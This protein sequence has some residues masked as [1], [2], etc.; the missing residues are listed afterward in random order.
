[1]ALMQHAPRGKPGVKHTGVAA[2]DIRGGVVHLAWLAGSGAKPTQAIFRQETIDSRLHPGD[3]IA[4][5]AAAIV[6]A[7]RGIDLAK[8]P[9]SIVLPNTSEGLRVKRFPQMR[10]NALASAIEL[11]HS[12]GAVLEGAAKRSRHFIQ[13]SGTGDDGKRF[14]EAVLVEVTE[15]AVDEAERASRSAGVR[16]ARVA[17]PALALGRVLSAMGAAKG[18]VLVIDLM[19]PQTVLNTYTDGKFLLSR[20]AD[21]AADLLSDE[22]ES[23]DDLIPPGGEIDSGAAP[24]LDAMG[25]AGAAAATTATVPGVATAIAPGDDGGAVLGALGD[26][27]PQKLRIEIVRSNR[28]LMSHYRRPI[29]RVYFAG[30]AR[31]AHALAS[32]LAPALGVPVALIDPRAVVRADAIDGQPT[33]ASARCLGAAL[34][35]LAPARARGYQL[36][37]PKKSLW[38]ELRHPAY[39]AAAAFL[40][41]VGGAYAALHARTARADA[42]LVTLRNELQ[43]ATAALVIPSAQLDPAQVESRLAVYRMLRDGEPRWS[44]P[45]SSLAALVPDDVWLTSVAVEAGDVD[46]LPSMEEILAGI[47]DTHADAAAANDVDATRLLVTGRTYD[48]DAVSRFLAALAS[49]EV[50]TD[51]RVLSVATPGP[52]DAAF[53]AAA[54]SAAVAATSSSQPGASVESRVPRRPAYAFSISVVPALYH[55]GPGDSEGELAP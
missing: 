16:L 20:E 4:A 21:V 44:R 6:R 45:L 24:V 25:F 34:E 42:L 52:D 35:L 50:L 36:L 15:S 32:R 49:S 55:T 43:R 29:E 28:Y 5:T 7:A 48:L 2:I 41:I 53:E 9:T 38:R 37:N 14:I 51:A 26:V 54:A 10:K 33:S 11:A 31:E 18:T 30:P 40:L 27:S 13:A 23:L 19:G 39:A 12:A 47:G 17:S 8:I 46:D 22:L 3:P 1:M